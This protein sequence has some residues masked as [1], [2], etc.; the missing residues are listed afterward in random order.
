[1]EVKDQKGYNPNSQN[2]MRANLILISFL[3]LEV[4]LELKVKLATQSLQ[5]RERWAKKF[6][7]VFMEKF[8]ICA[9]DYVLLFILAQD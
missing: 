9:L 7:I 5:Q 1:M 2:M 8:L 6:K 4:L 3:K